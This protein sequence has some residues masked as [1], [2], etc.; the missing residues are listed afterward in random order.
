M[1][2][3]E[4]ADAL[5]IRTVKSELTMLHQAQIKE[6]QDFHG[7]Q[8]VDLKATVAQYEIRMHKMIDIVDHEQI[9]NTELQKA[10]QSA[11]EKLEQIKADMESEM[12]ESLDERTKALEEDCAK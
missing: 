5:R 11:Q 7:E 3:T 2:K 4:T 8:L 1:K 9:M 12:V 10:N 6:I